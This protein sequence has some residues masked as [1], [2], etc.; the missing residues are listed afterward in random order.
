MCAV[1]F[2]FSFGV[3]FDFEASFRNVLIKIGSKHPRLK[4]GKI[5]RFIEMDYKMQYGAG[6]AM[7]DEESRCLN[8]TS[9]G[10]I[11]EVPFGPFSSMAHLS[12]S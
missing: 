10:A 5:E 3:I 12:I 9:N 7:I 1:W 2:F 6:W 4:N 8:A 11:A